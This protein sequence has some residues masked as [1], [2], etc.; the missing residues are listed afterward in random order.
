VS[1]KNKRKDLQNQNPR[2]SGRG[3][4][5]KPAKKVS[6]GGFR[7]F[8]AQHRR[9]IV[10]A[11]IFFIT[12]GIF[13]FAY[14]RLVTSQPFHGFMVFTANITAFF[15]NLT[16]RGV[17]TRDTVVSSSMFSFQIVDLC[18]AVMPM[19]ILTAA[20]LAFP[21]RIKEKVVG[22]LVGLLGIFIVNQVRLVSLYYIGAYAPGIFETAHLL[23]WQ[24]LMI[25]LAIGIWLIWV[26]KYVRSPLV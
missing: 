20:I 19:L 9:V 26:Y 11:L 2:S 17:I 10:P 3:F 12:V 23:V 21:S 22:L 1:K 24:S 14:Y 18:T 4:S 6:S 16:G 13:I 15:L 25:L 5:A 7:L 8:W